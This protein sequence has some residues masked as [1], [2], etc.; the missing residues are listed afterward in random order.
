MSKNFLTEAEAVLLS[1]HLSLYYIEWSHQGYGVVAAAVD[2]HTGKKVAIKKINNVFE[3]VSEATRILR[4]IKLLRFS[5]HPDI[6]YVATRWYRAPELCGSFY[7]K[8]F[9][10]RKLAKEDIREL[11]YREILE[12]RT[13]RCCRSI[14]MALSILA[15]IAREQFDLLEGHYG[16]G[17]R[18]ALHLR[19]HTSLPSPTR[20]HEVNKADS[21]NENVGHIHRELSPTS[22]TAR[23]NKS[24]S[25]ETFPS[26]LVQCG[27]TMRFSAGISANL[28]PK[29][30][31]R[32]AS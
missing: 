2:T 9:E 15:F 14:F 24:A 27:R 21:N 11:I 16:G 13:L 12:Y 20:S 10:R 26:V 28:K 31:K 8:N 17:G 6:D 18:N 25:I 22:N 32:M 29:I 23:C 3:H 5:R 1:L 4:E 19:R 7:S 30:T